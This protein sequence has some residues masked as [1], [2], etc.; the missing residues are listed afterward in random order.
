M[1]HRETERLELSVYRT[2][3]LLPAQI[4]EI[5]NRFV[6][7]H[8]AHRLAKARGFCRAEIPI[9]EGLSFDPDGEPHPQ[10]ANIVGWPA[11]KH[12]LKNVQQKIAAAMELEVRG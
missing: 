2:T 7:N 1:F 6:D 3:A 10:H 5:C 4:W 12:E 11:E 8:S 9:R